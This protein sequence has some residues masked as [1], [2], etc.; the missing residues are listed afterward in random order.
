MTKISLSP[1]LEYPIEKVLERVW[2][3]DMFSKDGWKRVHEA[4]A[5]ISSSS[6]DIELADAFIEYQNIWYE[7]NDLY[8][9]D[10]S[11]DKVRDILLTRF[12]DYLLGD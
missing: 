9:W 5:H 7:D 8:E 6:D 1:A 4:C 11:E 2:T 3:I 10:V 12:S